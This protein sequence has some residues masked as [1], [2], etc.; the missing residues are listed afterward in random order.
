MGHPIKLIINKREVR[1]NRSR[2]I[3]VQYCYAPENEIALGTCIGISEMYWNSRTSSISINLPDK[4]GDQKILAAKLREQLRKAEK[5]IDFALA[6]ANTIVSSPVYIPIKIR[7]F[8]FWR[9]FD[10]ILFS[11]EGRSALKLNKLNIEEP[12]YHI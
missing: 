8:H 5:L 1:N 4:F 10:F 3:H 9:P 7:K 6:K 2:I 12:I 11:C